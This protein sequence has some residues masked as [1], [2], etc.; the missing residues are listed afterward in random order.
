M[1]NFNFDSSQTYTPPAG[2]AVDFNLIPLNDSVSGR[3][4]HLLDDMSNI[5]AGLRTTDLNATSTPI[6]ITCDDSLGYREMQQDAGELAFDI[7]IQGITKDTKLIDQI[8]SGLDIALSNY[9]LVLAVDDQYTGDF[10]LTD[11]TIDGAYNDA[12][13]FSGTVVLSGAFL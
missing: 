11:L 9:T 5:I 2:D 10:K 6:D 12:I 7:P 1:A 13:A 4:M 3:K 8:N